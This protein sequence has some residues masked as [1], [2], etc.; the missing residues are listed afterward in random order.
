MDT[1]DEEGEP[2]GKWDCRYHALS[3]PAL[4]GI[5]THRHDCIV[6]DL[7]ELLRHT[8][9]HAAVTKE[10]PLRGRTRGDIR[11]N[12]AAG[13]KI[14]DVSIS[15][16]CSGK[17]SRT[18]NPIAYLENKKRDKYAVTMTQMQLDLNT[19]FIPFILLATGK[20]GMAA[21][22]LLKQVKIDKPDIG[23]YLTT[24]KR[25]MHFHLATG[26]AKALHAFATRVQ[27]VE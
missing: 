13:T 19:A 7:A 18:P 25:K 16:P 14:I 9:G 6:D 23:T 5:R 21:R 2:T 1:I 20:L 10:P 17:L 15:D 22:A 4:Q 8:Y 3:C 12:T 11:I 24:F 26:N 27:E